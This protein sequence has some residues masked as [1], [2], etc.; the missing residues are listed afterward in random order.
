MWGLSGGCW[1]LWEASHWNPFRAGA[2]SVSE[3][4]WIAL[5]SHRRPENEEFA[6]TFFSSSHTPVLGQA[7][8]E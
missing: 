8:E 7:R 4:I 3:F 2:T 6:L 1:D 5:L